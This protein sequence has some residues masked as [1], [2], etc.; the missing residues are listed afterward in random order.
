E[1]PEMDGITFLKHVQ[2]PP[3]TSVIF[4]TAYSEYALDAFKANATHYIMKPVEQE[5]LVLA[6]R[7]S[8]IKS[9]KKVR[10][11]SSMSTLTVFDGDEYLIVNTEDIVSLEADGSYTKFTLKNKKILAS[12]RIGY[13]EERLPEDLFLRCHN[14][15]IVNLN[16]IGKL[17]KNKSNYLV[18]KNGDTVPISTTKKASIQ[19][20][21]GI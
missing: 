1:M 14:S 2:L 19:K 10:S 17:G 6:V 9:K 7:K 5:E 18:M 11:S 20:I 3:S 13:Y 12:K 15:H 4:T 21:L 8:M 16:Q